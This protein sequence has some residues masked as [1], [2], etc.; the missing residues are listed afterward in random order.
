MITKLKVCL[1][2]A[3]GVGKTSV[4]GRFVHSIFSDTYR[5]TIGVKI[6]TQE[7]RRGDRVVQ[8]VIWDLSGEDEFQSVQTSYVAGSAGF[9]LVVD[10]TRRATVDTGR[11]LVGR[12]RET[13]GNIPF[14]VLVNKADLVAS[15]D[16]RH[17]DLA[18]LRERAFAVVETSARTGAGIQESF[19]QLVDAIFARMDPRWS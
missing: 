5:T 1:I 10:G 2:G 16:V 13:A 14:V 9:L 4:T 18:P 11:I 15:W 8:L 17:E 19:D 3:T 6:E 7:V 12:V